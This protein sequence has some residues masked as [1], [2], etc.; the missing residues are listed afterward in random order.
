MIDFGRYVTR[1][2]RFYHIYDHPINMSG[3]CIISQYI[4]TYTASWNV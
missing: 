3:R 2:I 1:E 4:D